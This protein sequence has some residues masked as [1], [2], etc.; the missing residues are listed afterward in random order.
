MAGSKFVTEP[1]AY[2]KS[3]NQL[4]WLTEVVW[5]D[6][7]FLQTLKPFSDQN[8]SQHILENHQQWD[9][10]YRAA[11]FNFDRLPNK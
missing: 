11:T 10:L 6:L 9:Q 1:Q 3:H 7:L 2:F 5:S 4:P 8:L